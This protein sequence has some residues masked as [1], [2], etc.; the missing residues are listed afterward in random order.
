TIIYE[1]HVKGFTRRHPGVPPELRG[2]YAG[3][4]SP[5][6]IRHLTELGVTAVEL[7]P[8]H[9]SVTEKYQADR[10]FTN[11]W[12]YNS[13]GFLCPDYRHSSSR[14]RGQQVDEL[15]PMVKALHRAG[16]EVILDVVYNHT[17]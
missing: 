9:H 5:A 16:I 3:L 4:A 13:I 17:A 7:L 2:T 14:H 1:T 8:V 10:G 11:Y 15:Q 12:G 6:A